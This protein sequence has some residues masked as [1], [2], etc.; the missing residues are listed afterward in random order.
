MRFA[1]IPAGSSVFLD[2]NV[3][4]YDFGPHPQ[5]GAACRDLL[6]RVQ[7]GEI[8]GYATAQ[9]ASDVAHRLMTVE[10][11]SLNAWP[12][13]GIGRRLRNHPQE[14]VKLHRFKTALENI[15]LFGVDVLPVSMT[16]VLDAANLSIQLGLL[17]N[18]ALIIPMMRKH[19]VAYLASGDSDFDRVPGITRCSPQ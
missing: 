9:E 11:C 1:D 6:L 8:K 2:A 7:N 19:G 5:F 4:I 15:P 16:D 3:F 17:S 10:A 12:W 13:Q 18:D 14:I